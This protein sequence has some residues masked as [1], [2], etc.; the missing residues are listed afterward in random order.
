MRSLGITTVGELA[1]APDPLLKGAFGIIGPQLREA[2][3][4]RDDTP[5]VPY[6]E[7]VDAKSMG[8][9]VTLPEDCADPRFL[10]G[11]LLRLS[12]QVTRRLRGDGYVGRVVALKLRNRRF[13]TVIRQRAIARHTDDHRR[14]FEVAR[15]LLELNWNGE[16]LRLIGV[17]VS[18]LARRGGAAQVEMFEERTRRLRLREAMDSVRD[19]W[20]EAMLVPAGSLTHRRELGH[21]PFGAARPARTRGDRARSHA[22]PPSCPPRPTES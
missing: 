19:R 10:A 2:A 21:V 16:P 18:G 20:G 1:R 17:S 7:G 22:T 6:H 13:E 5:L 8:H 12:D 9:E 3:W 14:V 4:G 15:E 11:T